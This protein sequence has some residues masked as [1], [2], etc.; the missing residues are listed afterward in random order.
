MAFHLFSQR[1]NVNY[2]CRTILGLGP[3]S[4]SRRKILLGRG[5]G[6]IQI[7]ERKWS[8]LCVHDLYLSSLYDTDLQL[9]VPPSPAFY[10]WLW[11]LETYNSHRKVEVGSTRRPKSIITQQSAHFF[12][13]AIV[14]YDRKL[15][16][17]PFDKT[18]NLPND[19]KPRFIGKCWETNLNHV[20]VK[21]GEKREKI[22][23]VFN[24]WF[25]RKKWEEKEKNGR[26]KRLYLPT[27]D[28]IVSEKSLSTY[29]RRTSAVKKLKT[30]GPC[31]N[32]NLQFIF[33]PLKTALLGLRGMA[34]L[35]LTN[36][37]MMENIK[38]I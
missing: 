4:W 37:I 10:L 27:T 6:S 11:T 35:S 5:S 32:A 20:P 1:A 17:I 25:P 24:V 30:D 22:I 12:M 16:F 21:N 23:S 26:K 3:C 9:E 33:L 29:H 8:E 14:K 31:R 13:V 38:P 19:K 28:L 7:L 2:G 15:Y 18:N 36:F 34:P